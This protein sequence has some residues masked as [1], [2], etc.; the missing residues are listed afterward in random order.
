MRKNLSSFCFLSQRRC[1]F[2][3]ICNPQHN[4]KTNKR[5]TQQ[6]QRRAKWPTDWLVLASDLR[7]RDRICWLQPFVAILV[8]V[9]FITCSQLHTYDHSSRTSRRFALKCGTVYVL[10]RN[11]SASEPYLLCNE[12]QMRSVNDWW[13]SVQKIVH[14]GPPHKKRYKISTHTTINLHV[15]LHRLKTLWD[16]RFSQQRVWRWLPSRMLR[17]VV[18]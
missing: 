3:Y 13:H 15:I 11:S 5:R 18:S 16:F 17:R 1:S 4:Y 10:T 9:C 12:E 6:S 8:I 2:H 7:S 14:P